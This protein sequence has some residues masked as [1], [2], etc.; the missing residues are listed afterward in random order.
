MGNYINCKCDH[1][2]DYYIN[3]VKDID[4]LPLQYRDKLQSVIDKYIKLYINEM[5]HK[6]ITY[7]NNHNKYIL[8]LYNTDT[9]G[10]D[11]IIILPIVIIDM[12]ISE[13]KVQNIPYIIHSKYNK[14]AWI[15]IVHGM[16]IDSDV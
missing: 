15:D 9:R 1:S 7:H 8:S 4:N 16:Y 11:D 5:M 10:T 14:I 12:L 2:I 6:N 13:L 3:T